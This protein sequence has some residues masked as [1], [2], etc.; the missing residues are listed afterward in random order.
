MKGDSVFIA[1]DFPRKVDERKTKWVAMFKLPKDME[2]YR[3]DTFQNEGPLPINKKGY[4][5]HPLKD[6][7]ENLK[8]ENTCTQR[9]G[10]V[11]IFYTRNSPLSNH[12]MGAPIEIRGTIYN[13]N[14]QYYFARKA[15]VYG[16]DKAYN[17]IMK[18]T[19]PAQMLKTGRRA[20]NMNNV[21][22]KTMNV[23]IMKEANVSKYTQNQETRK[24]LLDTRLTLLGESSA[25][26]KFW[27]TGFSLSHKDRANPSLWAPN[28]NKMG[29]ILTEIR[30]SL[31]S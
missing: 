31:S 18:A 7:P 11:T 21:D 28:G 14:E 23:A 6:V 29:E 17:D 22:W 12:Y 20:I 19:D 25:R 15:Q 9:H 24:F 4:G 13:C 26:N 8:T 2:D 10:N 27:G 16:D 3:E 5:V 1:T 30:H